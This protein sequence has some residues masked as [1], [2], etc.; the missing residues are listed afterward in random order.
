M[1]AK[2]VIIV[3]LA[4]IG[5]VAAAVVF[6][7]MTTGGEEPALTEGDPAIAAP[8]DP[9]GPA[10][11]ATN[12]APPPITSLVARTPEQERALRIEK[13]LD[14]IN[15]ALLGGSSDPEALPKALTRVTNAEPEVR[16]AAIEAVRHIGDRAAI[17]RLKEALEH[18]E[19]V[20]DKVAILETIKFLELPD[21]VEM[22]DT[23]AL[24]AGV[25]L[26]GVHSPT[27]GGARRTPP[28]SPK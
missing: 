27:Q 4:V 10:T 16:K 22:L 13:D 21:L 23:N 15:D 18:A 20:E 17:P 12:V 25:T 11:T 3:F 2:T 9:T 5:I 19:E 26:P 1:R 6:K 7:A 14:E 28:V 24:N 8:S